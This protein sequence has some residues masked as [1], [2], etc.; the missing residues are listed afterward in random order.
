MLKSL[1]RRQLLTA[2]GCHWQ[3]SSVEIE[4]LALQSGGPEQ[5]LAKPLRLPAGEL[6]CRTL[7][8]P[9]CACQRSPGMLPLSE[10]QCSGSH[11]KHCMT[12][13]HQCLSRSRASGHPDFDPCKGHKLEYRDFMVTCWCDAQKQSSGTLNV[14]GQHGILPMAWHDAAI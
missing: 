7:Q 9:G 6:S 3:S 4:V 14:P 2:S 11:H 8:A 12:R 13:P 5:Q 10:R 1:W